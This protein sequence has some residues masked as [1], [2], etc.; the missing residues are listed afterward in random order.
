MR[1]MWWFVILGLSGAVAVSAAVAIYARV[2]RRLRA[3]E[4][5]PE[6]SENIE[7]TSDA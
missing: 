4:A 2:R 5:G 6:T 7:T 3:S 1:M